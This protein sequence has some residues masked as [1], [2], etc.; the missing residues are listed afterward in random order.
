MKELQKI[1]ANSK[2]SENS[3]RDNLVHPMLKTTD[4]KP[5]E[6]FEEIKDTAHSYFTTGK[7]VRM[8]GLAGLR[9][10]GKT[11]LLW[12]VAD[13]IYKNHTTNIYFFHIGNLRR[14]N[15]G[16]KELQ[17]GFE[18]YISKSKLWSYKEKIVLLFDEIHEDPNWARDL[19]ILYDEFRIAFA[20][21]TGSS[22]LLLQST[23]DLV[24]R[25]LIQ[26]VFPLNFREYLL[27]TDTVTYKIPEL[28]DELENIFLRSKNIK[29]L[30]KSFN[31]IKPELGNY[32]QEVN[33]IENCIFDYIVYYNII[34]LL[35][36]DNK[37]QVN[38]LANELIRRVIYEDIPKL[39]NDFANPL[40]VEKI[41]RRLA[42]SDEINI[43]SLSQSI[44]IA[45]EKINANLDVLVKAE[46]LNILYPYGGIDSKINKA[47]KYY[48]MSPSIRKV[49]LTPLIGTEVDKDLYAKML[50]DI[51][52]LYLKRIFKQESIVS[53]SSGKGKKNPDLIIET[54]DKPILLEIGINKKTMKQISNSRIKYKYG[55]IVNSKI[56]DIE[57]SEN[58]AI[59]PLKY[60]LLL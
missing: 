11:T 3:I 49:I 31:T 35:I 21:A 30:L 8:I 55:I 15:I 12:Q 59:I 24:T 37:L 56:N 47:Q 23:A 19:K 14:Y 7:A 43:Q 1:L 50:E 20:V 34:R 6:V 13:F 32:L 42:A 4:F 5:R 57:I 41:L 48:F 2:L 10:T 58:I 45:Q 26:H 38:S 29:E 16:I 54:I 22:A 18:T 25:M 52:V 46:L 51:V 9:G 60:F 39:S 36:A 40:S 33:S 27:L 44:G 53:F 17:E 28:R